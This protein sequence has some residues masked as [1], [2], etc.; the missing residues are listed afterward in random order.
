MAASECSRVRELWEKS[1][2]VVMPLSIAVRAASRV[3]MYMSSGR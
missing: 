2:M 1:S 3:P